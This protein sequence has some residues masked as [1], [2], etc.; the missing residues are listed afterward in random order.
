MNLIILVIIV[1]TVECLDKIVL[2][3]GLGTWMKERDEL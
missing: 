1:V 2:N 3:L